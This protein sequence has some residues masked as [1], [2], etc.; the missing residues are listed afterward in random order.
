MCPIISSK[1]LFGTEQA[2]VSGSDICSEEVWY[3]TIGTERPVWGGR[4]SLSKHTQSPPSPQ[5]GSLHNAQHSPTHLCVVLSGFVPNVCQLMLNTGTPSVDIG[6][7]QTYNRWQTKKNVSALYTLTHTIGEP[8]NMWQLPMSRYWSRTRVLSAQ[9]NTHVPSTRI[10]ESLACQRRIRI[11]ANHANCKWQR[12]TYSQGS[13]AEELKWVEFNYDQLSCHSP[14]RRRPEM[15]R[16]T[17]A[18]H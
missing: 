1:G 10:I 5:V 11:L 4:T 12:N 17:L 14:Q 3:A 9:V 18:Q 16:H 13:P 15:A 2:L 8:T 7:G 6:E